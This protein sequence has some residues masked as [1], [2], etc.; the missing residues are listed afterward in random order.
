MVK[1]NFER[2]SYDI[3][4]LLPCILSYAAFKVIFTLG[5]ADRQKNRKIFKFIIL[6]VIGCIKIS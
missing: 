4:V 6:L 5:T 2:M 3:C 1:S